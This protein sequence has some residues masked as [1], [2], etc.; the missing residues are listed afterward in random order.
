V[1]EVTGSSTL[2]DTGRARVLID[3]GLFQGGP[4]QDAKNRRRHDFSRLDAVVLSHAHVD[5]SGRLPLLAS[6]GYK[7]P[8]WCTPETIDLCRVM[9]HDSAQVQESDARED[10]RRNLRRGREPVEPLY[11]KDEA[12]RVLGTFRPVSY[13]TPTEV[14]PGVRVRLVDAGH[15]LGSASVEVTIEDGDRDQHDRLLRRHRRLE[16]AHQ[17]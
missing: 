14:A 9:L 7:G 1:G 5:H 6:L 8:I 12:D 4:G 17:P 15:I 16:R 10:T 13:E 11:T 3:F 2:I